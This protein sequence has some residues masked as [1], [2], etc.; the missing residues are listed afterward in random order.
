MTTRRA[1]RCVSNSGAI[2]GFG[3][4][5]I[6]VRV[7]IE[8]WFHFRVSFGPGLVRILVSDLAKFSIGIINE[9][10]RKN[11]QQRPGK[12]WPKPS[13]YTL[14]LY[15][16]SYYKAWQKLNGSAKIFSP[17][18]DVF[19]KTNRWETQSKTSSK[20][21]PKSTKNR[22]RN[23]TGMDSKFNEKPNQN[24]NKFETKNDAR[25]GNTPGRAPCGHVLEVMIFWF[26]KNI[27][28]LQ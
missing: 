4:L 27:F 8:F 14:H 22:T 20:P 1:P 23:A 25:I 5:G 2:F 21:K 26:L 12:V 13:S 7:F 16:V 11:L 6:L 3:F 15:R 10:C 17:N 28:I 9:F 18:V 24:S 19:S